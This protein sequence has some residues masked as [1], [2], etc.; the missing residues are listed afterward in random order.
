M[1]FLGVGV[2]WGGTDTLLEGLQAPLGIASPAMQRRLVPSFSMEGSFG[3]LSTGL[4]SGSRN[5]PSFI[6]Q[7]IPDIRLHGE[8]IIRKCR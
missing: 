2:G 5:P 6:P 7:T 3:F 1:A 8:N 4:I